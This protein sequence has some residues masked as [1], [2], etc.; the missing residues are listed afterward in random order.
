[1]KKAQKITLVEDLTARLGTAKSI[2]LADI[3]GIRVNDQ[4]RLRR[5]LTE[6]DAKLLVVKNTLIKRALSQTTNYHLLTTEIFP[7]LTGQTAIIISDTNEVEPVQVLGKL[8]KE[9]EMP[10]LKVGI[11]SG[12]IYDESALIRISKLPS[13]EAL[14]AQVVGTL[15]GPLYGLVGTLQGNLQKLVYVLGNRPVSTGPIKTS[16]QSSSA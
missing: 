6:V 15:T 14:A 4:N 7:S 13:R 8:I 5:M 3:T 9:L 10:R 16:A 12:G 2:V 1:M 11:I